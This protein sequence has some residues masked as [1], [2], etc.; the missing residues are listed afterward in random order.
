MVPDSF[1]REA[2]GDLAGGVPLEGFRRLREPDEVELAEGGSK[3]VAE[4]CL[5]V[6]H[7]RHLAWTRLQRDR[8]ELV[9]EVVEDPTR[10]FRIPFST[11]SSRAP[12]ARSALRSSQSGSRPSV[13]MTWRPPASAYLIRHDTPRGPSYRITAAPL[14]KAT[15]PC[16]KPGGTPIRPAAPWPQAF[17][18]R[19]SVS[20]HPWPNHGPLGH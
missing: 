16:L 13:S 17:S 5:V 7:R 14:G 6:D 3:V 1:R 19:F 12:S 2:V 4:R 11:A 20:V 9:G 10:G 8:L 18:R 15:S